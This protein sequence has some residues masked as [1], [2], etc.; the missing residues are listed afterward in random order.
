MTDFHVD[1]I[2]LGVELFQAPE[3]VF[4]VFPKAFGDLC[5]ATFHHD[6]ETLDL[7][8]TLGT[9]HMSSSRRRA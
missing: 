6:V 9:V 1:A 3:L 4:H 8:N 7:I 2:S 5:T